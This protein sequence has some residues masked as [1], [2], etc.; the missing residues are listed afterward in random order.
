MMSRKTPLNFRYIQPKFNG[1]RAIA[2]WE[3]GRIV[4]VSRGNKRYDLPHIINVISE[5]L[6][7]DEELGGEIYKHGLTL[8]EINR[9]VKKYRPG[10]TEELEYHVYDYP[11]KN[12]QNLRFHGLSEFFLR[13]EKNNSDQL[14][15]MPNRF[16]MLLGG[17]LKSVETSMINN[18]DEAYTYE[19]TKVAE[20]YE[21]AIIRIPNSLY[22]YGKKVKDLLKVKSFKDDEFKVIDYEDGT[23]KNTGC[24]TFICE[25]RNKKEFR[26]VPRGSYED[27]RYWYE[28][29]NEFIGRM[30]TV[31]YIEFCA[32]FS[33][34]I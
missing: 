16:H 3:N 31:K 30:L 17:P 21:G 34:L 33:F 32:V 12:I 10:L 4:L 22:T 5:I 20:G 15:N 19:K 27:K 8:Q 23:G 25:T 9:R 29:G 11:N 28:H 7:K 14:V 1:V 18:L 2:R 13:Y 26:V 24:I 6:K